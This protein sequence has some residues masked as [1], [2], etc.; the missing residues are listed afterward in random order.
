MSEQIE[1]YFPQHKLTTEIGLAEY[2]FAVQ[3][4]ASVDR[5]VTWTTSVL[6][7]I[8]TLLGFGSF[9]ISELAGE[10]TNSGVE[11][12]DI[13][14]FFLVVILL[15]S[16]FAI[17]HLANLRKSQ[18]FSERKIIVLRRMLG[19]SYGTNTLVLPN[20]RIE[21]ADDPFSIHLRPTLFS[22]RSMPVLFIILASLVS[23]FLLGSSVM[24]MTREAINLLHWS[25]SFLWVTFT[26]WILICLLTYYQQLNEANENWRL[27]FARFLAAVLRVP[28]VKNFEQTIYHI[29][30]AKAEIE[31][32][33]TDLSTTRR[34]AIAVEDKGFFEHSGISWRGLLRAFWQFLWRGKRS[35]G[36]SI[37]QQFCRSNFITRLQP[38]IRRKLVEM[39][40]AK[41]IES[42]WDK[43][44]ILDA[45]LASVRFE[46][47]VYGVHNAYRHFFNDK[48]N[49]ISNWE[50]FILVERLANTRRYFLGHRVQALLIQLIDENILSLDDAR[51][52]L[53]YYDG[54][55]EHHFVLREG[56]LEPDEVRSN[57][58]SRFAG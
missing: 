26:T 4:L 40:L 21:G 52:A 29:K 38:T 10:I 54:F 6:T 45:Y 15:F 44:E 56:E 36:S 17:I 31:R 53:G 51:S 27:W 13:R 24:D 2:N 43:K 8:A 18:T 3:M 7:T 12:D 11:A 37:T 28:L 47:G 48:A 41:W 42:V 25:I 19:V 22:Y 16:W 46:T 50:A 9:K 34:I 23:I 35:G 20:W 58:S 30:L 39:A 49:A 33:K 55:I 1:R 5:A 32:L 57:L 14:A